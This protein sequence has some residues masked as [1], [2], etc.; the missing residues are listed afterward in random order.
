MLSQVPQIWT[1]KGQKYITVP[2]KWTPLPFFLYTTPMPFFFE[3]KPYN[4]I[5]NSYGF[6]TLAIDGNC[7]DLFKFLD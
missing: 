1:N 2:L 5:T 7:F 4:T 6:E 3:K